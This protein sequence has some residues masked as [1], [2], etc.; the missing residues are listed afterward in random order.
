MR[1]KISTTA[2]DIFDQNEN[3]IQKLPR[4]SFG[5]PLA[6]AWNH[7][8]RKCLNTNSSR[9]LR[10]LYTPEMYKR[11]FKETSDRILW[12]CSIIEMSHFETVC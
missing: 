12:K 4:F 11:D 7:D 5:C 3:K 10:P 2:R 9:C 8:Q 6:D 1:R